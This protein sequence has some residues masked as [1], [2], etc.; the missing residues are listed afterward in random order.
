VPSEIEGT[1]F[2]VRQNMR[3]H[4]IS[5]LLLSLI[6][7]SR[8]NAECKNFNFATGPVNLIDNDIG[9]PVISIKINGVITQAIV[10]TGSTNIV[11]DRRL[12]KSTDMDAQFLEINDFEIGYMKIKNW[13]AEIKDFSKI[14]DGKEKYG[15]IIG[16][17][18][19]KCKIIII[20]NDNKTM[21]ISESNN[22]ENDLHLNKV[23]IYYNNDDKLPYIF[24]KNGRSKYLIDT[25]DDGSLSLVFNSKFNNRHFSDVKTTGINGSTINK[26]YSLEHNNLTQ[27][28][29]NRVVVTNIESENYRK[30]WQNGSIG[31]GYLL[32]YNFRLDFFNN[33]FSFTKRKNFQIDKRN[34]VGVQLSLNYNS[35]FSIDHVMKGS[36]AEKAGLHE[37]DLICGWDRMHVVSDKDRGELY[38]NIYEHVGEHMLIYLCNGKTYR[39]KRRYFY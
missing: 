5:F 34:T 29:G 37:G 4:W 2:E 9:L 36:P 20:D 26:I 28:S 7:S 32:R 24:D 12:I 10:D 31:F 13:T 38:K 27:L 35:G 18:L 6:F 22:N 21:S 17:Q 25:G 23:S 8:I 39:I 14:F 19:L 15:A 16:M 30:I 11:I 1:F 33:I 3:F